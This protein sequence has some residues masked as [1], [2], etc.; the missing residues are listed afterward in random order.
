M[1][2]AVAVHSVMYTRIRLEHIVTAAEST[3][4]LLPSDQRIAP[5]ARLD[6]LLVLGHRARRG[7]GSRRRERYLNGAL[8]VCVL[9]APCYH[10]T[11]RKHSPSIGASLYLR[12][13]VPASLVFPR[14]GDPY[15]RWKQ[16]AIFGNKRCALKMVLTPD[17]HGL[18]DGGSSAQRRCQHDNES[19][20]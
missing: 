17:V 11:W 20:G 13:C 8:P 16:S 10:C 7:S 14:S 3:P 5:A 9:A 1:L 18:R 6:R 12:R 15:H 19:W 4:R 2:Y